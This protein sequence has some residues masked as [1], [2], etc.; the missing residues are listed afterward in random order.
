MKFSLW[1][2]FSVVLHMSLCEANSVQRR[3]FPSLGSYLEADT[4]WVF[5]G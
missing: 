1:A 3:D 2:A 4:N 5:T